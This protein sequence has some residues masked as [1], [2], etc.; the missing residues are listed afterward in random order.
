MGTR[1]NSSLAVLDTALPVFERADWAGGSD[2][3]RWV[4]TGAESR[5]HKRSLN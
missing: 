3:C 1:W 4:Q 5:N 2:R